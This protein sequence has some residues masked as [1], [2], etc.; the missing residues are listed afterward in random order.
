MFSSLI[1]ILFYFSCLKKKKSS[2]SFKIKLSPILI[3]MRCINHSARTSCS[4][5]IIAKIIIISW[6]IEISV[7]THFL[8]EGAK[9]DL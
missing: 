2:F 6:Y 7:R 5:M 8:L 3:E 4:D 9:S 1:L